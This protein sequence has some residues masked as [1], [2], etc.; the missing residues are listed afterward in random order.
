ML[1]SFF[2]WS[3]IGNNK[4]RQMVFIKLIWTVSDVTICKYHQ[5]KTGQ[6]VENSEYSIIYK[7][8]SFIEV[9]P[10]AA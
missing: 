2:N 4:L 6:F 3:F 8:K 1:G 7:E 5:N 9:A 10:G